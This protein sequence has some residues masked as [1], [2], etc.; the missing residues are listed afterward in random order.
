[1]INDSLSVSSDGILK[2]FFSYFSIITIFYVDSCKSIF[3]LSNFSDLSG[4]GI[5]GDCNLFTSVFILGYYYE[6]TIVVCIFIDNHSV[7][8]IVLLSIDLHE[9]I[10]EIFIMRYFITVHICYNIMMCSFII[11]VRI[12]ALACRVITVLAK[13]FI[14]IGVVAFFV[15]ITMGIFVFIPLVSL[16]INVG[17]LSVPIPAFFVICIG[18]FFGRSI[19]ILV[20][21]SV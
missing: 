14:T 21:F 15:G 16:W 3:G 2:V 4:L 13:N 8:H 9:T 12:P 1:M 18:G 11:N 7:H 17:S 5:S 10:H 6:V 20:E 19:H